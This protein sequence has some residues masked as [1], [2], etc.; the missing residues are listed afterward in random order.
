V[1]LSNRGSGDGD[2][3][4]VISYGITALSGFWRLIINRTNL[5][6]ECHSSK[7]KRKAIIQ[8]FAC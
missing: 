5:T 1:V 3:V 8:V 2:T 4:L 6:S 7:E